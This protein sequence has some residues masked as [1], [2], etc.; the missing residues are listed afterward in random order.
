MPLSTRG[1]ILQCLEGRVADSE[2]AL[3]MA[4]LLDRLLGSR[5]V[6]G[7][8]DAWMALY[9]WIREDGGRF[10]KERSPWPAQWGR[11]EFFLEVME[12]HQDLR[13]TYQEIMVAILDQAQAVDFFAE[14]GMPGDRGILPELWDCSMLL[15]LPQPRDDQNLSRILARLFLRKDT[16]NRFSLVPDELFARLAAVTFPLNN[17][18]RHSR[19]RGAFAD[20]FRLLATRV[21]AQCSSRAM[22]SRYDPA[23]L[24]DTPAYRLARAGEA[25][26]DA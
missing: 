11:L 18:E 24:S 20:A 5:D 8:I 3:E 10:W 9:L 13:R 14:T 21:L 26:A 25:L 12:R 2:A 22:R 15:L 6:A 7:N 16:E 17:P 4:G 1:A 23:Q 19:V